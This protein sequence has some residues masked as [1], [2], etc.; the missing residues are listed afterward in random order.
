M[1]LLIIGKNKYHLKKFS[2]LLTII[3]TQRELFL[4]ELYKKIEEL[5]ELM[6]LLIAFCR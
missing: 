4:K 6:K 2:V 1:N 5:Q 3:D